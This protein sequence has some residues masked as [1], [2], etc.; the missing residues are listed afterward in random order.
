MIRNFEIIKTIIHHNRGLIIFA[1]HLGLKHDFVV[2]EGSLFGEM[3]IYEYRDMQ[4]ILDNNENPKQEIFV[5]RPCNMDQL[6]DKRF[7]QGQKVTLQT[8]D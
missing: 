6:F 8:L 1:K 7:V 5:F 2:A 3:P 4:T